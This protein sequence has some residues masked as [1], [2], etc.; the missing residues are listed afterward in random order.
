[1]NRKIDGPGTEGKTADAAQR[2]QQSTSKSSKDG[3]YLVG[4]G[5]KETPRNISGK[6]CSVIVKKS[7]LS[8]NILNQ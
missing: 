5:V 1:M 7:T 4:Y 8:A 2:I 6:P 3:R